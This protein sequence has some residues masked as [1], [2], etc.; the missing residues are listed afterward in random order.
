MRT[1]SLLVAFLVSA[2][3]SRSTP[4]PPPDRA[5][6]TKPSKDP[7][8]ARTMIASGAVVI[9]VRT[10][11]EYADDHLP[12]AINLPIQELASRMADVHQLVAGDKAR[13]IVVYCA[14]G[15]RAAKAKQQLEANGYTHVVNGGGID[16]LR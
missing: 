6:A 15:A 10:A 9:D 13:P 14:A 7:A 1:A 12:R 8:T 11:D 5:V 16:D 4:S 2:G 3:C